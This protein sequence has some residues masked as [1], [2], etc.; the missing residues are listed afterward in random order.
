M[1]EVFRVFENMQEVAFVIDENANVHFAN[2]AAGVLLEVSMR[3][4]ASGKPLENFVSFEPGMLDSG[5]ALAN[6]DQPSQMREVQFKTPDGKDGYAQVSVQAFPAPLQE[7]LTNEGYGRLWILYLRDVSLEKV[8]HKKYRGELDQKETVIEDLRNAQAEL[9]NYSKN[10][11][12]MVEARTKELREAN[13]LLATILDSL[14]QGILVFDR[15]GRCLPVFSKVCEQMF[16]TSPNGKSAVDLLGLNDIERETFKKWVDAVF[17]EMLSFDDLAPLGPAKLTRNA[18]HFALD[19]HPMRGEQ[20]SLVGV[21]LVA[22]DK[23]DEINARKEAERERSYAKRVVQI[24]QHRQQFRMFAAEASRICD[25]M[26]EGFAA[27]RD[28]DGDEIARNLHTVKGGAASFSLMEMVDIAHGCEDSLIAYLRK[29]P[30]D[31]PWPEELKKKI[32]SGAGDMKRALEEFLEAHSFLVGGP[33]SGS[34]RT[35]EI[36][37]ATLADWHR[38]MKDPGLAARLGREILE[39]W[40]H[41]PVANSFLHIDS[42]IKELA[43][44][45]GKRVRPLRIEGGDLR[46]LPE[47][48]SDLFPT[49][50][51]AFRN[52]VDHGLETPEERADLGKD[53]EGQILIKF[54]RFEK[55]GSIRLKVEIS[56]DGRGI[57]PGKIRDGLERR[58][59]A[60]DK[61]ASDVEIIQA[62]FRDDFSTAATL[63]NVSG[64][65][66]GLSAIKAQAEKLGGEAYI[67][68]TPGLGSVLIVVVPDPS[69]GRVAGPPGFKLVG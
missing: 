44:S 37:A 33:L 8:L 65:G 42:S 9:E 52:A 16:G 45:L 46:V 21:V 51:H 58:G 12:A 55:A 40:V 29:K 30:V 27:S 4:M 49:F 2:G 59:L 54:D 26:A 67:R 10:L 24:V 43:S 28:L 14:G 31:V 23:T 18:R 57:D 13:R 20:K 68:S 38:R 22:T 62:V 7:A 63:T 36:P 19:F 6:I 32:A 50:I 11:E 25:E 5:E 61:N 1:S 48:F 64:R 66:V 60:Y 3:K 15:Q 47:A 53:P 34:E 35:V 56:D 69:D 41:E 17:E 39:A